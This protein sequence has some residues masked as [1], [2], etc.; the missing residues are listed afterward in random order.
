MNQEE[1]KKKEIEKLRKECLKNRLLLR[2][3]GRGGYQKSSQR[4]N[5]N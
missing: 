2:K 3:G 1:I 5:Q 4:N